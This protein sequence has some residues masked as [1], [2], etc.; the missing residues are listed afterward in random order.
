[1]KTV[2]RKF[3]LMYMFGTQFS[4]LKMNLQ[5]W[6]LMMQKTRMKKGQNTGL[7]PTLSR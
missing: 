1:M 6:Q 3:V 7:G 5:E 4:V 2:N